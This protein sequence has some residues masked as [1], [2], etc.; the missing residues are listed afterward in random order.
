MMV[1]NS[2]FIQEIYPGQVLDFTSE[3]QGD[4]LPE[5]TRIVAFP[6]DPKPHEVT[7]KQWM[8]QHWV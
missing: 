1:E 3:C 5:N 6:R 8:K 7:E 2:E 4:I